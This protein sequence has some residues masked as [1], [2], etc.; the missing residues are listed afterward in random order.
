MA[1]YRCPF[2]GCQHVGEIFTDAHCRIE[3]DMSKKD[4]IKKHGEPIRF[5]NSKYGYYPSRIKAEKNM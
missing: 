4:M 1:L 5:R 3:H 2:P